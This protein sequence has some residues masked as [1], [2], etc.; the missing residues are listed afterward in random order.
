MAASHPEGIPVVIL[1]LM[2]L[3]ASP[4]FTFDEAALALVAKIDGSTN[5]GRDVPRGRLGIR[6]LQRLPRSARLGKSSRLEALPQLPDRLADD[7]AEV[8]VGEL[9]AQESP[10]PFEVAVKLLPG[11]E[12]DLVPGRGERL[13]DGGRLGNVTRS[14]SRNGCG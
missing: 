12:L 9:V 2:A 4:S 1:E 6:L 13:H 11:R 14:R 8:A 10:K 7:R 3:G 5:R